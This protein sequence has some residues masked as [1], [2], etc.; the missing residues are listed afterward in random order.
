MNR[1]RVREKARQVVDACRSDLGECESGGLNNAVTT[2]LTAIES[3][4]DV[5]ED[6]DRELADLR[7]RLGG[8]S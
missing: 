5:S 8:A 3:L 6:Q 1:A 7:S 4:C 2:L